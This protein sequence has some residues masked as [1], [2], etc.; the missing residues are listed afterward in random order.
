[1]DCSPPWNSP[2]K[3]TEVGGHSFL[4]GIFLTQGLNPGLLHCRQIPYHL[5]HQGSL[6][7]N[8]KT[9]KLLFHYISY[10]C[11]AVSK[12]CP[13]LCDFMGYIALQAPLSSTISWSLLKFMLIVLVMLSKH[14]TLCHPLLL[15]PSIFPRIRVFSKESACYIRWP[16]YWSF[17]FSISPSNE[18]SGLL[19]FTIHWFDIL[20]VQGT[21]KSLLYHHNL[22]S[23]IPQH[24][25]FFRVQ[26]LYP[27]MTTGKT[28]AL[29]IVSISSIDS[30]T[31]YSNFVVAVFRNTTLIVDKKKFFFLFKKFIP[32]L[33]PYVG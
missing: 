21:L 26:L 23:S 3:N 33:M 20:A 6:S 10:C 27:H 9:S 29:T 19:F 30:N 17:S 5:S 2:G 11:C 16:K 8:F 24:S 1:M 4:Q 32:N 25:A 12:S 14:L 18:D 7:I 31:N 13:A 22:K 28:I 15:L